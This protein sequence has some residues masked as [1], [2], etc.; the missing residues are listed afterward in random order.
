[1]EIFLGVSLFFLGAALGSFINMLVWRLHAGESILGRSYCDHTKKRLKAID[2]IPIFSFFIF[3]GRCRECQQKLSPIYPFIE[4]LSGLLTVAAFMLSWN[5]YAT[6]NNFNLM[7][8]F[9]GTAIMASFLLIE[10]FFGYFD[11]LYWEVEAN[12]IYISLIFVAFLVIINFFTPLPFLGNSWDHIQ[13]GI[14]LASIIALV[15]ILSNK[16]GM[17]EGDIFLFGLT[18]LMLGLTGGVI[19]FMITVFSGSFIGILKALR[20]KKLNKVKIQ[21]APFIAFGTI[22]TLLFQDQIIFIYLNM[23]Y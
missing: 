20:V 7:F 17:G 1:M 9:L 2:L 12:S 3:K 16:G 8:V 19:A 18:G 4:I 21:L 6:A 22:I 13:G 14:V 23:I 15:Y 11:Y 10:L 5:I